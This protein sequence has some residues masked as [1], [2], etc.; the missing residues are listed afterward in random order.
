M[1][2]CVRTHAGASIPTPSMY[3][4]KMNEG[5]CGGV[6][7][8][9]YHHRNHLPPTTA[10]PFNSPQPPST[11]PWTAPHSSPCPHPFWTRP[12]YVPFTSSRRMMIRQPSH[13]HHSP[14]CP[15]TAAVPFCKHPPHA[16][17]AAPW[18]SRA[19]LCN[20]ASAA[21]CYSVLGCACFGVQCRTAACRWVSP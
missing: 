12:P 5:M 4:Y 13:P 11:S 1:P 9:H 16:I 20:F 15:S 21:H 3:G 17:Q 7:H 10:F 18:I 8:K 6:L 2:T 14:Q 19:P